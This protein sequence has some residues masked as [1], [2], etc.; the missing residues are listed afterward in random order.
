[1]P[2]FAE[3]LADWVCNHLQEPKPLTPDPHPCRPRKPHPSAPQPSPINQAEVSKGPTFSHD[4]QPAMSTVKEKWC[5]AGLISSLAFW[6]HP[7]CIKNEVNCFSFQRHWEQG[8]IWMRWGLPH[9]SDCQQHDG[10]VPPVHMQWTL[11]KTPSWSYVDS[12]GICIPYH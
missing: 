10:W 7:Q 11:Q 3:I 8:M 9:S 4:H 12:W 1:M 2:R 5:W 6:K